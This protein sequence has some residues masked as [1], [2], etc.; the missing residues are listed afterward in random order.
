MQV[1]R[2]SLLNCQLPV[3]HQEHFLRF[4]GPV[5]VIPPFMDAVDNAVSML[6]EDGILGVA[7]FYTSG[8]YDLPNR[9]HSYRDRWFWRATFDLDGIDLS[10]ERRGYL[11]HNLETGE[12]TLRLFLC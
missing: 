8:K 10:P 12:R 7:D 2:S 3:T 9:Q 6:A 5:A 1:T 11:D 4:H